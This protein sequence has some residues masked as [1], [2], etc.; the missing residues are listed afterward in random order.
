MIKI[1]HFQNYLSEHAR[2]Y[3][4]SIYD[5]MVAGIESR[6]KANEEAKEEIRRQQELKEEAHRTSMQEE[7]AR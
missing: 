3:T 7:V 2:P 4:D 5:E 1:Y 6:K